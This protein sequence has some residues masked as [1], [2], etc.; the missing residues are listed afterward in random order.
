MLQPLQSGESMSNA[1]GFLETEFS[2][3]EN[4]IE[5]E[6]YNTRKKFT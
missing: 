1:I 5:P 3:E 4:V 2:H 6:N